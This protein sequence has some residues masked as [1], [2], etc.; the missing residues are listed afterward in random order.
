MVSMCDA[1]LMPSPAPQVFIH[2]PMSHGMTMQ[3]KPLRERETPGTLATYAHALKRH[4]VDMIRSLDDPAT[5]KRLLLQLVSLA[6]VPWCSTTTHGI[7]IVLS[8]T[9]CALGVWIGNPV[10]V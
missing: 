8:M 3:K 9:P 1:S 6:R 4:N 2:R 5:S 10:Q 7:V